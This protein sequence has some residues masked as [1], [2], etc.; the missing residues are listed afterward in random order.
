VT[1]EATLPPQQIQAPE[2]GASP[3]VARHSPASAGA[4]PPRGAWTAV[5]VTDSSLVRAGLLALLPACGVRVAG[6]IQDPAA[7]ARC[8][9]TTGA[10]LAIAAP[11]DG[12]DDALFDALAALAPPRGAVVLLA[13]PGFRIQAGIV[14]RRFDLVCLPLSS[15]CA[16]LK[17][18]IRRALGRESRAAAAGP[19][20]DDIGGM[21]S[22]REQD[23]LHELAQGKGNRAI[24]EALWVSEDTVKSHLQRIY[25]KLGVKSRAAAVAL[26]LGRLGVTP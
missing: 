4:P 6:A 11:A 15:D 19:A 2:P 5:V 23:V 17:R 9:R 26:Y 22:T 21:L 25:R 8:M 18:G 3:G 14:S 20:G 16:E 13:A 24:A 7:L 10:Q 1:R 12:G